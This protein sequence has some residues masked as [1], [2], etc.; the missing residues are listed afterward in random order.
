[1]LLTSWRA[2]MGSRSKLQATR[3]LQR[4]ASVVPPSIV[5]LSR[6]LPGKVLLSRVLLK[7]GTVFLNL[8]RLTISKSQSLRTR[9]GQKCSP[10]ESCLGTMA[11]F[12]PD[13]FGQTTGNQRNPGL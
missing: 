9:Q 7:T 2:A 1:M 5:P 11:Y 8:T 12:A 13:H 10:H 3:L 4:I 6:F